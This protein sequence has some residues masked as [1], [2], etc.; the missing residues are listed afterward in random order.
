MLFRRL[1]GE[2]GRFSIGSSFRANGFYVNI[3]NNPTYTKT[4]E[5]SQLEIKSGVI[6]EHRI[7]DFIIGTFQ[8]G[9]QNFISNRLTEKGEPTNDFI[10][11]NTQ[12]STGYFQIGFSI[13]PFAK[14]RKA[15]K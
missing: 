11:K 2:N 6:Y 1:V 4:Y 3:D 9:F 5:Y 10:Y 7:S 12:K 8:G 15:K 13:D 14:K